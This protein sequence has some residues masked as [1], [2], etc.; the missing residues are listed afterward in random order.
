[1]KL[2]DAYLDHLA[3]NPNEVHAIILWTVVNAIA[4]YIKFKSRKDAI[5]GSKGADHLWEAPEYLVYIISWVVNPVTTFVIFFQVQS[6]IFYAWI[7][8]GGTLAYTIGGRWI[9]EW[10]LAFKSGASKV[11]DSSDKKQ[12]APADDAPK[13]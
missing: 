12:A 8:I 11:D 3:Q 5:E 9:F 13:Q 7:V 1:M 10:F 6:M 2:I 4:F